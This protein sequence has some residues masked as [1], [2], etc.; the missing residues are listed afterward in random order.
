MSGSRPREEPT[1]TSSMA[2]SPDGRSRYR[3]R[4]LRP[5]LE[6]RRAGER[7]LA[8]SSATLAIR[9]HP[10]L[11]TGI[12]RR[13]VPLVRDH[14]GLPPLVRRESAVLLGVW[15]HGLSTDRRKR[16]PPRFTATESVISSLES[17]VPSCSVIPTRRRMRTLLGEES[18]ERPCRGRC[19]GRAGILPEQRTRCGD[20][21]RQGLRAI[22]PGP[23]RSRPGL[24]SPME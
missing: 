9:L 15:P 19:A 20:R 2:D 13:A 18:G 3:S 7:R 6:P 1:I 23:I 21:T 5:R 24:R 12:G 17:R 22:A 11:Q 10:H 16:L 14:G 8:R 4:G